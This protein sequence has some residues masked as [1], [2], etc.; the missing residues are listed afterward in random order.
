MVRLIGGFWSEV[1]FLSLGEM[2]MDVHFTAISV[3]IIL[4]IPFHTF[5]CN[6]P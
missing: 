1:L 4:S 3:H 5:I 2:H 6:I